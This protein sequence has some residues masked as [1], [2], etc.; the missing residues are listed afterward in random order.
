MKNIQSCN[1]KSSAKEIIN[2]EI[3]VLFCSSQVGFS[4]EGG[5]KKINQDIYFVFDNFSNNNSYKYFGVW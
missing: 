3:S 1:S 5:P 4:G 2:K